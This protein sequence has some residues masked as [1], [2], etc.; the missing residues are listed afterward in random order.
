MTTSRKV[1]DLIFKIDPSFVE[2]KLDIFYRYV[3]DL[4]NH[5]SAYFNLSKV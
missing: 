2:E 4:R 1:E 3:K 5:F